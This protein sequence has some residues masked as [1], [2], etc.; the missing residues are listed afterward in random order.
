MFARTMKNLIARTL[1][2]T[3]IASALVSLAYAASGC[4]GVF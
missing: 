2:A 3:A 1:V 4:A